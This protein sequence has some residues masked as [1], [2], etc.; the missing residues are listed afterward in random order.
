VVNGGFDTAPGS[1]SWQVITSDSSHEGK[2][3][4]SIDA[5]TGSLSGILM[6]NA[7]PITGGFVALSESTLYWGIGQ[8]FT[9]TF[10]YKSTL[11]SCYASV[12]AKS[13]ATTV[14]SDIAYWMSSNLPPTNTWTL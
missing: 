11:G 6:V 9:L 10:Y 8:S 3:A 1:G 7:N 5:Q 14:G 12:Y 13:Q 4:Q 2:V